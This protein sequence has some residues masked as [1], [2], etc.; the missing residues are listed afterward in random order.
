MFS[1][2]YLRISGRKILNVLNR[3]TELPKKIKERQLTNY[4]LEANF[5]KPMMSLANQF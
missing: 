5:P 1:D 4:P 3:Q 2:E